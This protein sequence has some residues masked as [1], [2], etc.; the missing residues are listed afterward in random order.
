[1]RQHTASD[2]QGGQR[3]ISGGGMS[4]RPPDFDRTEGAWQYYGGWKYNLR[5]YVIK[6][7]VKALARVPGAQYITSAYRSPEHNRA[8]GGADESDHMTGKGI[9]IATQAGN[10]G[11]VGRAF[12]GNSRVRWI[13]PPGYYDSHRHISWYHGGGS[14][15]QMRSGGEIKLDNTLANLHKGETV[16]TSPLSD[17]LKQN[18]T[19]GGETNYYIKV[20]VEGTEASPDDIA[21]RVEQTL[22][23]KE[24]RQG[25]G[26]R[27]A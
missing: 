22:R 19:N 8:V 2:V 5:D 13:S 1:M 18:I 27:R 25:K 12:Q 20:N 10:L 26:G 3:Q 23:Q 15:P 7:V 14:I 6:D 17:A 11:A 4:L 16:L 21:K 24:K 9:D